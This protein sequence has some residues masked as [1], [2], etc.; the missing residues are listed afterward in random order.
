MAMETRV[1][2]VLL[3]PIRLLG[4]LASL[5][6]SVSQASIV[7]LASLETDARYVRKVLCAAVEA[8]TDV[9]MAGISTTLVCV[10]NVLQALILRQEV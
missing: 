5:N 1:K 10:L 8:S 3:D 2:H 6:A 9:Q 4:A 7:I